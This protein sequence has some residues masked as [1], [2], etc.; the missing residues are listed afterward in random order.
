[1]LICQWLSLFSARIRRLALRLAFGV[2]AMI[3]IFNVTP[4]LCSP[5][6]SD[7][8]VACQITADDRAVYAIVLK[9]A[10]VWRL[11]VSS[12]SVQGFTLSDRKGE[13]SKTSGPLGSSGQPLLRHAS[14][15]TRADFVAKSTKSCYFGA[16][17]QKDLERDASG[18]SNHGR[19]AS[20]TM[21]WAGEIALS[22]VGFN[23]AKDEAL[24]YAESS[25]N[26][27]GGGDLF[28]LRKVNGT[29]TIVSATNLWES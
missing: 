21:Y 6:P 12:A 10:G 19:P 3:C 16:L 9:D 18:D 7:S 8:G 22:R 27:H 15:E 26:S 28:L 17:R 20:R 25:R 5:N 2:S 23:P 4:G 13:W 14:D 29:W 24:I 11:P 1:M